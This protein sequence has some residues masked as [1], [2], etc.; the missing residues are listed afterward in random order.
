MEVFLMKNCSQLGRTMIEVIGVLAILTAVSVAINKFINN[1]H[2][3]FRISRITQQITDLRKNISNRYVANGDYSVIKV[4]EMIDSKVI[5]SDMVDN[6][7]VIHAYNSEVTFDGSKDT[8]QVTFTQ[9]P[10]HVCVELAVMN[11]NFGGS[12][13][14]Y[15]LKVN[16]TEFN[17]PMLANG[18]KEL[19]VTLADAEVAC[20]L[21]PKDD[22]N[23]II[24]YNDNTI[25]WTFR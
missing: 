5:P 22:E 17:W 4:Q 24:E 16:E 10:H 14:L 8:Y 18:G 13:E 9:L 11:W 2:D 7:K 23:D 6:G 15:R 21:P 1:M 12:S 25:T 20:I 19:S 3:K